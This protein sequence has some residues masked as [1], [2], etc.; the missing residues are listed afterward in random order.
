LL[1]FLGFL[2]LF[3]AIAAGGLWFYGQHLYTREGP[4]TADGGARIVVI[5]KGANVQ[6]ATAALKEAGAIEDDFS[7]RAVVRVL[8]FLPGGEKLSLKAGEYSI[9]SG[10]PMK[11]VIKQLSSGNSLQ[12]NVVIPEGVTTA[13][14]MKR[15]AEAEWPTTK[16]TTVT[17]VA[18]LTYRL[19]GEPPSTP[20]EGVM[21]PGDYAVQRGDTIESVV[22]RAIKRQQDLLAEAWPTR[23][24]GLPFKTPEEAIN[25]ASIV[26][27]ETGNA[28]ERP[29]VAA[30][31]VNRLRRGMRLQSDPTIIYGLTRGEPLGRTIR[32]SEIEARTAWNT[33][34]IAGLPETP[35]CNPG[36]DA[37][38]AV[39][40]PPVSKNVYFVGDGEGGHIFAETYA[41]HQRN[42][43]EYWR[44]REANER[45]GVN[46]PAVRRE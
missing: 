31:F 11:Q 44:I 6:K 13:M 20:A 43:A 8:D 26:E 39:L 40:N 18:K 3:A 28:S 2:V 23:Q 46:T 25:L 35:I 24:D 38:R 30:V 4:Q 37:I 42:V 7:F 15:L 45:A 36:A 29:E 12:Y 10:A 9:A 27:K 41:E 33:Y 5:P 34:Q 14:V 21:L 16:P 32:K 17:G 19:A 22:A 1:K